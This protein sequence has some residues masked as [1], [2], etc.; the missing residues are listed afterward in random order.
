M[1]NSSFLFYVKLIL[2]LVLAGITV[3]KG[4]EPEISIHEIS[5][6]NA[7]INPLGKIGEFPFPAN[8]LN[9]RARGYLLKG[10]VKTAVGNFGN[11]IEWLNH[12]A[13]L[14]GDY[15]YLPRVAF[16]AG[17]PGHK[18]S[19]HYNW[20]LFKTKTQG[21][22]IWLSTEAANDWYT[23][24]N[25]EKFTGVIFNAKN[26]RGHVGELVNNID[27]INNVSQWF[28]KEDSLFISLP[29]SS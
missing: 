8:P 2:V 26:D 6:S 22:A 9:D 29:F 17:V 12:P 27:Q 16:L 15:T 7:Q 5:Q 1:N 28:I 3:V 24:D 20:Q 19:Y 13:G 14:W 25:K 23:S 4:M 18:Y 10:K 21:I 11:F